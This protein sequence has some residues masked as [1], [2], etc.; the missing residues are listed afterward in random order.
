MI[1]VI[2]LLVLAFCEIHDPNSPTN[3]DLHRHLRDNGVVY[4]SDKSGRPTLVVAPK[5][6]ISAES[7]KVLSRFRSVEMFSASFTN[8]KSD[9]LSQLKDLEQLVQVELAYSLCR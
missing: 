5:S 4:Q 8:T 7:I 3:Q 2:A 9:A 1:A 6:G